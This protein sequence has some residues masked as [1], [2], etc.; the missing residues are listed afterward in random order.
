MADASS[1]QLVVVA[2]PREDDYVWQISSEKVPHMT[3]LYLGDVSWTPEQFQHTAEFIQHASSLL[4]RFWMSVDR[5]GTLG[6]DD[7]DVLF[8]DKNRSYKQLMKFRDNLLVDREISTAYQSATQFPEWIPHLTLGFPATPAKPLKREYGI[9][10]VEFDKIALWAADSEGP[11]FQLKSW[12]DDDLE[13][14]MSEIKV[15]TDLEEVL[16]HFGVKGMKWGQHKKSRQTESDSADAQKVGGIKTRVKT[17]KTT[18]ILT[19][20]ELRDALDRMR[21]EQEFS[22]LSGG[23]DKTRSQKAKGFVAKLLIDTGKQSA[24]QAVKTK[25]RGL[26]DEALKKTK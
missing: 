4:N 24:D 26:V 8:F 20:Q 6:P 5:R 12:M 18:K 15:G 22:K 14:A 16:E 25:A 10:G 2:I 9:S 11:T 23:L 19:N 17:Q 1:M 13:V 3:L 21:L 7:A